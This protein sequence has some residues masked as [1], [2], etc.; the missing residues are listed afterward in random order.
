MNNKYTPTVINTYA[1][2]NSIM[3]MISDDN[4]DVLNLK[5]FLAPIDIYVDNFIFRQFIS[6][7]ISTISTDKNGN[8]ILR[9]EDLQMLGNDIVGVKILTISILLIIGAIPYCK[10]RYDHGITEELILKLLSYV[11]LAIIPLQINKKWALYE[12]EHIVNLLI[13]MYQ[14]LQ[15]SSIIQPLINKVHKW[16]KSKKSHNFC[17]NADDS[18]N[19][20]LEKKLSK[21]QLKLLESI[22]VAREKVKMQQQIDIL[23]KKLKQNH[24]L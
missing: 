17:V 21:I 13:V 3:K 23:E 11:F 19:I 15:S 2:K 6:V 24:D 8:D 22:Y 14:I 9:L 18:K 1:F 16:F 20:I 7:V 4:F 10:M 12:K 5:R